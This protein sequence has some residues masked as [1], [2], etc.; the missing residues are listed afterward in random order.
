MIVNRTAVRVIDQVWD[1]VAETEVL[2]T[3][4]PGGKDKMTLNVTLRSVTVDFEGDYVIELKGAGVPEMTYST[5]NFRI[6]T[7][8]RYGKLSILVG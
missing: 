4:T 8:G 3:T 6:Q 2:N 7:Y 5:F 1:N